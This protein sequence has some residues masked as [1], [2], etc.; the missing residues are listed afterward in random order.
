MDFSLVCNIF[1]HGNAHSVSII[2]SQLRAIM[3]GCLKHQVKGS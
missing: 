3:D 2:K 1:L